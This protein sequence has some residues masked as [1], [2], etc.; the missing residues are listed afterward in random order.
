MLRKIAEP[1]KEEE[2]EYCSLLG[3]DAV[4]CGR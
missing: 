2:R 4:Q 3:Y 1:N